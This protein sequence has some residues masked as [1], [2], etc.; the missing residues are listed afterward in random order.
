MTALHGKPLHSNRSNR[1]RNHPAMDRDRHGLGSLR[2]SE[3]SSVSLT[4]SRLSIDLSLSAT[5]SFLSYSSSCR[6]DPSSRS[7]GSSAESS[8][9][10]S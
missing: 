1:S 7:S 9:P 6:S 8:T 4:S 2:E 10:P 3:S 5:S